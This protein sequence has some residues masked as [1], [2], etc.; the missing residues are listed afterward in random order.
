MCGIAGVINFKDNL[1]YKRYIIDDMTK[2][3][4]KRGPDSSGYY[5]SPN[6]L[7]GHRRLVVVDPVG[8]AQPM[9]RFHEGNKYIIV[10]NGELYNT[11]D[12]RKEL[13]SLGFNFKSYSDTEVLLTS[14]I[15]WGID[16]VKKLNG[17]FSFGIWDENNLKLFLCRDPLGVKPLYY[18]IKSDNFIFGSELKTLLAH[19]LVSPSMDEEGICEIFGLG[20]AHSLDSGIFKNV[21]SLPPANY[22]I[23]SRDDLKIKEYW[24]LT[25]KE[26]KEDIPSTAEHLKSLLTD[27]IKRQLISDVPLCTFLSGGLDSSI[28][29]SIVASDYKEK[30]KFLNTYSIDYKDNNI[31]FNSNAF[32]P[33][34]DDPWI[35]RMSKYI[36]SNHSKI[37]IDTPE[38]TETLMD[39]VI[40]NDMPGMADIDSS[41]YLFC[42]EVRKKNTVA[43][44]GECADEL[45]GGYPWF[46]I[47][48]LINSE[49]FPWSQSIKARKSILSK[50]FENVDIEAYTHS[51]YKEAIANAPKLYGESK[52]QSRMRE[53]FYL[54][55]KWF[56]VT[57]LTR[58]DRMSMFNSLEVRVPFADYRIVEY[59]YNIP[60]EM[61]FYN[62]REKGLLR[63][64]ME[65]I[66]PEDVLWRK[67]SPYPKTF[68]PAYTK[69]VATWLNNIIE[70]KSSPILQL[71]D[72]KVVKRLVETNG[73]SFDGYWFGQLM[74]GPQLIA[75]LI[76]INIWMSIYNV[77][78]A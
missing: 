42:K 24:S 38:L 5:V 33:D 62:N 10:Y 12:I 4:E 67:K 34:S 49:T 9:I 26:H 73:E 54:N 41:L 44:S 22:L 52:A 1:I 43:L 28:I 25:C 65:G 8:G 72:Y 17:I 3:L 61:K 18:T 16:C 78:I 77:K 74:K 57:L 35:D 7:L 60:I 48:E 64:A 37:I 31:Y 20:P 15:A 13:I 40:A 27:A 66:L 30:G 36:N 2:T 53:I 45:F 59:A 32:Q 6:A 14:Y 21:Y 68:N 55:L 29:S 46:R 69:L 23:F 47:P 19:P 50:E 63:K 51:R 11:E 71:I 75:Y 76:Q 56:M 70:D 39:S 58:K